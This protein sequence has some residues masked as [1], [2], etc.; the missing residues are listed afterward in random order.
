MTWIL[1][2]LAGAPVR[3]RGA[4]GGKT[5]KE[6]LGPARNGWA[7]Q[8]NTRQGTNINYPLNTFKPPDGDQPTHFIGA[9]TTHLANYYKTITITRNHNQITITATTRKNIHPSEELPTQQLTITLNATK[10]L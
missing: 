8:G 6:G 7:R 1:A 9:L 2:L 10:P 5:L 4:H 3:A